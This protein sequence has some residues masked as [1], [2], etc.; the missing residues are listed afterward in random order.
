MTNKYVND[1]KNIVSK[2]TCC[3]KFIIFII[4]L[5]IIIQVVVIPIIIKYSYSY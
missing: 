2:I 4:I 1:L 5:V 3:K